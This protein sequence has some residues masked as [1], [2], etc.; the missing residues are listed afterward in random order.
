MTVM[1]FMQFC[2]ATMLIGL[3]IFKAKVGSSP[4]TL[5]R[6]EGFFDAAPI[7]KDPQTGLLRADYLS[8]WQD[9]NGLNALLQNYWMVIH[10]PV[11]FL[12]FASTLVPFS[13]A[14]AGLY[15]RDHAGW[16]KPALQINIHPSTQCQKLHSIKL[17]SCPSQKQLK[18]YS[19]C[20][21]RLLCCQAYLYSNKWLEI[22]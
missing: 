20:K 19:T 1:S 8:L 15:T 13:F 17:P 21:A 16:T 3:Y 18:R 11:L 22:I 6:H 5:L 12:G 7:F 9:G 10:P 14:M 2:L 4:F